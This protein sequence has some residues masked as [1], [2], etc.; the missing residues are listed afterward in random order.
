MRKESEV[1]VLNRGR[2]KNMGIIPHYSPH[3]AERMRGH[4][5][6]S[7]RIFSVFSAVKSRQD[8][9][10]A[11]RDAVLASNARTKSF[12]VLLEYPSEV[13]SVDRERD[14]KRK[15][16]RPSEKRPEEK[17]PVLVPLPADNSE[18]YDRLEPGHDI[19]DPETS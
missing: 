17:F 13:K 2:E 1:L 7:I 8:A 14:R 12:F 4:R 18:P 16:P 3:G 6:S 15:E 10:W 11:E 5:G 19:I 9:S